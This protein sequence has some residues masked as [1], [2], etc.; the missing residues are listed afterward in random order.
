MGRMMD[1]GHM[2]GMM[3][4]GGRNSSGDAPRQGTLAETIT[5]ENFAY[6]PGNLQ[7]PVGGKVTW[8]NRDPAPPHPGHP[9]CGGANPPSGPT[10]L[11]SLGRLPRT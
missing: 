1:G 2:G 6:A 7:L 4:G 3:G 9:G 11:I 8:T 5:I 10:A